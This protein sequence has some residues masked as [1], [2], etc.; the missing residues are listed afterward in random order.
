MRGHNTGSLLIKALCASMQMI[1]IAK[2]STVQYEVV[3]F[4]PSVLCHGLRLWEQD[5]VPPMTCLMMLVVW[6]VLSAHF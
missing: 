6:T 2:I 4:A 3:S 5:S 1:T